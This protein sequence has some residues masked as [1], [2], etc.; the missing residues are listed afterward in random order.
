MRYFTRRT[1]FYASRVFLPSRRTCQPFL[2]H[3]QIARSASVS[4]DAPRTCET[5]GGDNRF[6]QEAGRRAV[7]R[8]GGQAGALCRKALTFRGGGCEILADIFALGVFVACECVLW[9]GGVSLVRRQPRD[10]QLLG[11]AGR[12]SP[13]RSRV[14]SRVQGSTGLQK[15]AESCSKF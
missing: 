1:R 8:Q 14:E 9:G 12:R 5:S 6:R 7:S 11:N 2:T 10:T 4:S 3:F 13:Q 15:L